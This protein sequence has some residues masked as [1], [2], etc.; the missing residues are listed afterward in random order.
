MAKTILPSGSYNYIPS[1]QQV[2]FSNFTAV[3]GAVFDF[4]R[5][6]AIIDVTAGQIIYTTSG[7]SSGYGGNYTAPTL[8]LSYNTTLFLGSELQIIYDLA[9]SPNAT[10]DGTG[11]Q[12]ILSRTDSIPGRGGLDI[13]LLVVSLV[14]RFLV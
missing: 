5:L 10:Y 4:T 14:G 13:I 7:A 8:F 1:V 6:Y 12:P 3:T 11:T 2:D 9:A